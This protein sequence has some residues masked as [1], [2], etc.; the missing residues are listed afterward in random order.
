MP[1]VFSI[2]DFANAHEL[3]KHLLSSLFLASLTGGEPALFSTNHFHIEITKAV[4]YNDSNG[5][6]RQK[7]LERG[8]KN[9][10][11]RFCGNHAKK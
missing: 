8:Q 1:E 6:P 5:K 4:G 9:G 3:Y 10:K 7:F 11:S 2:H